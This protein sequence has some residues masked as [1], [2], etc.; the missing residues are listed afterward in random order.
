[1]TKEEQQQFNAATG[2]FERTIGN[3]ATEGA[4]MASRAEALA[5]Q[6]VAMT[7]ERDTLSAEV[8]ALKARPSRKKVAA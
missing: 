7:K 5:I 2:F 4:N 1:M 8:A 6:L 3:V